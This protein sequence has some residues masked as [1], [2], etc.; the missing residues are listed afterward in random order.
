MTKPF[1]VHYHNA[2]DHQTFDG[3]NTSQ[4]PPT[5]DVARY[6][7]HVVMQGQVTN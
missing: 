4:G 1:N 3:G 2:Y 7:N 6:H 5:H